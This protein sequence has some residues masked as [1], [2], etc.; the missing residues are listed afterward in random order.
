MANLADATIATLCAEP[1]EPQ[2]L[3]F[4]PGTTQKTKGA[5]AGTAGATCGSR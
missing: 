1:A 4:E 3:L 2:I 5:G